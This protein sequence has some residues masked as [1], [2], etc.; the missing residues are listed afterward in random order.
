MRACCDMS[1][2]LLL[3]RESPVRVGWMAGMGVAGTAAIGARAQTNLPAAALDPEPL[4]VRNT[5]AWN[6]LPLEPL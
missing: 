6:R 5:A 1:P 2:G 3:V 4:A